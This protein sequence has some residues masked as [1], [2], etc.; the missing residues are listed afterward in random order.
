MMKHNSSDDL[1]ER[2]IEHVKND[3]AR[4]ELGRL[5]AD[6]LFVH[7]E[8]TDNDYGVDICIE[9]LVNNG[10]SPSSVAHTFQLKSSSKKPNTDGTYS[11]SVSRKNS[12]SS[13]IAPLLYAISRQPRK[14][15]YYRSADEVYHEYQSLDSNW[16]TPRQR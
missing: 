7:R 13:F 5:L 12:F 9:A 16:T 10:K 6:P 15:F 1:P 11:Y 4:R 2:T 3:A 8:E 14:I